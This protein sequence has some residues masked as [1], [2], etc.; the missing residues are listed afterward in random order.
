MEEMPE[1]GAQM[2]AKHDHF[3][4]ESLGMN[5]S[6]GLCPRLLAAANFLCLSG[7]LFA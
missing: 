5:L 4:G 7:L 2:D 6:A 1:K 3:V